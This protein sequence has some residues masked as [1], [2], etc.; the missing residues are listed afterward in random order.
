MIEE[1]ELTAEQKF[2]QLFGIGTTNQ[3]QEVKQVLKLHDEAKAAMK[4]KLSK[5]R[6]FD[7][8]SLLT[9]FQKADEIDITIFE[10]DCLKFIDLF[11]SNSLIPENVISLDPHQPDISQLQA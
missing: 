7:K 3:V 8:E 10:K 11:S 2:D 9:K 1:K 4:T 5:R 6:R